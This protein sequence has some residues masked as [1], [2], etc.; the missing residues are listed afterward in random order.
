MVSANRAGEDDDA[1][2]IQGDE[3]LRGA[4]IVSTLLLTLLLETETG[5]SKAS[6]ASS[7]LV[8]GVCAS[9]PSLMGA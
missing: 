8:V 9:S 4:E 6:S 7:M 2:K 3:E 1:T 5:V